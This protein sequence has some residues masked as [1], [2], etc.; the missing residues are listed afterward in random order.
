VDFIAN[1]AGILLG[2]LSAGTVLFI[3]SVGLSVTMGLMGFVNLAHGAFAMFGGYVIVLSMNR[4]HFGFAAALALGF[5]ATAAISVLLERTLYRR[6]YRASE[7]DQVLFTIGL[8]F[9]FIA[10][11][12]IVV[13]PESQT[14][15]L[16]AALRGQINLGFLQYRTYSIFLIVI[17]FLIGFGISSPSPSAAAW[18]ESAAGWAPNSWASIRNTR[19]NTW[20]IF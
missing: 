9:I 11:A 3:V 6:L 1:F 14:L 18:R 13:G 4:A 20:C 15:Q 17:G 10:G 2:G 5:V 12:I 7:L 19:S 16:P 8:I